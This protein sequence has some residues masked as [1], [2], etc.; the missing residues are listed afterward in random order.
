MTN[1]LSHFRVRRRTDCQR[2]TVAKRFVITLLSCL[3]FSQFVFAEQKIVLISSSNSTVYH[4]ALSA[5]KTDLNKTASLKSYS[6]KSLLLK[7]IQSSEYPS[8]QAGTVVVTIGS[9]AAN[10]AISHFENTPILFGFITRSAYESLIAKSPPRADLTAVFIDQPLDRLLNLASLMKRD[11]SPFRVG[12]LNQNLSKLKNSKDTNRFLTTDIDVTAATLAKQ[13]NPMKTIQSL[14]RTSDI[15]IVRPNTSLFNRLTAKLV[16][17]LSMRYKTPVIGFSK[18]YAQ[19]G[20]LLSLY[21]SPEDIG[22]DIADTLDQWLNAPEHLI[23]GPK[24][25]SSFSVEVNRHIAKKMNI[26]LDLD[27]LERDLR[28]ME[29]Q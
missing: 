28:R 19:A 14:M 12:I 17:Q 15:F 1:C 8:A 11:Q 16:L 24:E 26:D 6:I 9:A 5:F 22:S 27:Q 21:A 20:A 23:S 3:L 18:N 29:G 25:G 13:D 2:L 4:K 10:Y 7:D